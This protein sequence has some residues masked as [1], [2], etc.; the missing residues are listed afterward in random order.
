[1]DT[2]ALT[3]D[4]IGAFEIP[5]ERL[6]TLVHKLIGTVHNYVREVGLTHAEWRSALKFFTDCAAITTERR[7]EFSLLSDVLGVSSLVDLMHSSAESTPGS[8][9]GPFH[10]HDSH[11]HDNGIDLAKGQPG[12]STLFRGRV[13]SS[14]GTPLKAELDFWQNADNGRYPQ[15]DEEQDPHNL[16]CKLHTD[17]SGNFTIRT[18]RPRPYGL[19]EDGPVGD[20][21]RAGGRNGMRPAHFHVIV[22]AAGHRPVVTEIF[23]ADDEFL[24]TDAVFG[25]RPALRVPFVRCHDA[26]VADRQAMPCPFTDV[27]FDFRL[28]PLAG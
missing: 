3:A 19:P 24:D 16:R 21:L 15:Q 1:M 27:P 6:R 28:E 7:N 13:L 18:L 10:V 12:E 4:V 23:P 8:V 11:W 9:L 26:A 20:L 2:T 5:D 17:D 22:T 14:N 25:V